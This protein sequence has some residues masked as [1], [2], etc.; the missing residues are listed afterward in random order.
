MTDEEK[1]NENELEHLLERNYYENVSITG[2]DYVQD[3]MDD[4]RPLLYIYYPPDDS[5]LWQHLARGHYGSYVTPNGRPL[6]RKHEPPSGKNTTAG[7]SIMASRNTDDLNRMIMEGLKKVLPQFSQIG[8]GGGVTANNTIAKKR[9]NKN[10]GI[11][12]GY[13]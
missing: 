12:V 13:D 6:P 9:K 7:S 4:E 3:E 1:T 10:K 11:G 8:G 5:P 2:P